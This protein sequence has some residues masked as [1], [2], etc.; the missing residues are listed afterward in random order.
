MP[1][2]LPARRL[3]LSAPLLLAL[4]TLAVSHFPLRAAESPRWKFEPGASHRYRMTQTM[5]MTM[6]LGAGGTESP[7]ITNVFDYTWTVDSVQDNGSA[8]IKQ[9]IDRVRMTI[10]GAGDGAL[11]YD[12]ESDAEP[13]GYAAMVAPLFRA[14]RG[15]VFTVTMTPRG[16]IEKVDVPEELVKAIGAS[17]GA[18]LLGS[19]ATAEGLQDIIGRSSFEMPETIEPGAEWTGEVELQNPM[20]G[21]QTI[22]TTYRYE[23][24]KE[25]EGVQYESFTPKLEIAFAGAEATADITLQESGGEV[26]FNV[27]EGR[28]ESTKLQHKMEM[29]ITAAGNTIKQSIDQ[30]T[31]LEWLPPDGE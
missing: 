11:D 17:P 21:K 7:K 14:M 10:A 22:K 26:L 2:H 19:L 27:A 29:T 28:L 15:A 20:F 8:V 4:L 5:D 23:G 13:Q 25:L 24:P 18:A 6:D 30:A 31:D 12:S 1:R 3:R 9:T 16:K